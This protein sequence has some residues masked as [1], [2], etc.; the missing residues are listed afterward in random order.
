MAITMEN[1]AGGFTMYIFLI[2]SGYLLEDRYFS[3]IR[4]Q[5]LLVVLRKHLHQIS[6]LPDHMATG[7]RIQVFAQNRS[8]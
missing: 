1:I 8:W 7:E 6:Q 2:D 3:Q 4:N 5:P